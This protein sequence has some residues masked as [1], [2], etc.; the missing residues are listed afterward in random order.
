MSETEIGGL[1][2]AAFIVVLKLGGGPLLPLHWGTFNLAF[3]G[4][5][6]PVQEL[7]AAAGAAVPLLLPAPGQRVEVRA[8]PV[9]SGWW[10]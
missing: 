7:Q 4:W 8:V 9:D 5:R 2:R 6:A 10:R 3:H 1:L